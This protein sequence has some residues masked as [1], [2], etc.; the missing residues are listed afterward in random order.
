M[1]HARQSNVGGRKL[2]ERVVN[3]RLFPD[4]FATVTLTTLRMELAPAKSSTKHNEW[5]YSMFAVVLA[6]IE[7]GLEMGTSPTLNQLELDPGERDAGG[8]IR[9]KW[10]SSESAID[11]IVT[12]CP[13]EFVIRITPQTLCPLTAAVLLTLTLGAVAATTLSCMAF[14]RSAVSDNRPRTGVS[15]PLAVV[16]SRA[17]RSTVCLQPT[18]T[19][20][21]DFIEAPFS[22][23]FEFHFRA[24]V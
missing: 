3:I 20:R 4:A 6:A 22:L 19:R 15:C 11:T 21:V 12:G 1:Q 13:L 23:M 5:Q 14:A 2:V 24:M 16:A 9:A 17:M 10:T 8:A 7:P 18:W